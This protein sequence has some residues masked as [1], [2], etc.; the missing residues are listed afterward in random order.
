MFKNT[1]NK[2]VNVKIKCLKADELST[3]YRKQLKELWLENFCDDLSK[4]I[5]GEL[6]NLMGLLPKTEIVIFPTPS[7]RNIIG[8]AFMLSPDEEDLKSTDKYYQELKKQKITENDTVIYNVVVRK[9]DRKKGYAKQIMNN[10]ENILLNKNRKRLVLEVK[11]ENKT[12]II[13]YNKLN[14]KVV[15]ATPNGF[16]MEKI[17]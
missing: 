15:L 4:I 12:A 13:F 17:L 9:K 2:I 11:A 3:S 5:P 8:C 14:Y 10:I 7:G 16:L 1:K 6:E